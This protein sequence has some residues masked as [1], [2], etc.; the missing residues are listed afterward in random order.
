LEKADA[1]SSEFETVKGGEGKKRG[2][3]GGRSKGKRK[4]GKL[5]TTGR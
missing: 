2:G 4:G 3:G 5:K 1:R